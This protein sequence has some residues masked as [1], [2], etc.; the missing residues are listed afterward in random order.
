MYTEFAYLR[1]CHFEN[2][3]TSKI[4]DVLLEHGG[5]PYGLPLTVHLHSEK[6]FGVGGLQDFSVSRMID[7]FCLR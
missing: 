2:G 5:L 6:F 1:C 4:D 3:A 7:W